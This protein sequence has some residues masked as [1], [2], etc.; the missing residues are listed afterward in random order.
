MRHLC[1][2]LVLS[3]VA[4]SMVIGLA[5]C[6]QP[7]AP[8]AKPEVKETK[9]GTMIYGLYQQPETLDPHVSGQAVTSRIVMNVFDGLLYQNEK[10]EI[11]PHLATEYSVN[12]NATEY[13]FKL[14]K[15]VK[16]HDGEPFNAEAVKY[17]FDRIVDPATKS[18]S[19]VSSMGPY[20][21][22]EIVDPY[23]VKVK[24]K[25]PYALFLTNVAG[26]GLAPV[27]PKAAKA[28][29][30]DFG[31]KPVGTGPFKFAEWVRGSHVTLERNP[32]YNWGPSSFKHKGAAY[33]DKITF[34]FVTEPQVRAG[35]VQSGELLGAEEITVPYAEKLK[36]DPNFDVVIKTYAGSPRRFPLNTKKAPTNDLKVRQAINYG[37]D[38]KA[39]CDT[40]FK[41]LY[42]VGYGPLVYTLWGYNPAVEKAYPYDAAKAGQLLDE[43]GWKLGKDG[44]RV[45]SKGQ[46]LTLDI[47]IQAG[48]S[49][50]EDLA[51]MVQGQLKKL[52]FDAKIVGSARPAWYTA[53]TEGTHNMAPMALWGTDPN[54]LYSMYHSSQVMGGFNWSHYSDPEVDKLTNEARQIGDKA[55]RE[56]IYKKVQ[57]IVYIRDAAELPI[58]A[59]VTI[60]VFSKKV[61][62][63]A[64]SFSSY[65]VFFDTYVTK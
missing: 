45:N 4:L 61:K 30:D 32:D 50:H 57:E 62:D 26:T 39:V 48:L 11:Q 16:F 29:A 17:T 5:G 8:P 28:S 41:G 33:L 10:G 25:E 1:R 44:I 6:A 42:P 9:G 2:K 59:N 56:E 58:H 36:T 31:K 18:Q 60:C 55:R 7:A 35:A 63:V 27:S 12:A 19:A 23:T 14:R 22:T 43:A 53:L 38:R 46:K 54:I 65:P 34:K 52:G 20:A 37:V 3:V 40:L 51:Q 64:W 24:F 13:T 21:G 15:D 49:S 47:N